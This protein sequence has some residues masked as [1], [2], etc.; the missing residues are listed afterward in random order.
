MA[1]CGCES[2]PLL[3]Y[4]TYYFVKTALNLCLDKGPPLRAHLLWVAQCQTPLAQA[5]HFAE[6]FL[7]SLQDETCVS[8]FTREG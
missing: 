4:I 3:A 2:A 1:Q 8:R 6:D 7:T 5:G